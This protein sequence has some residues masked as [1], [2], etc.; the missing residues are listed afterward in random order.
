MSYLILGSH[1]KLIE[2]VLR[3]IVDLLNWIA[4]EMKVTGSNFGVAYERRNFCNSVVG[5]IKFF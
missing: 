2:E 1:R 5:K 4:V 3:R